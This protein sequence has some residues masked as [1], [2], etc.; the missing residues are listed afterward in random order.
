MEDDH[1]DVQSMPPAP[2]VVQS[3]ASDFVEVG[4]WNAGHSKDLVVF[5]RR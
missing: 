4:R 5:H 2:R 3:G 1:M